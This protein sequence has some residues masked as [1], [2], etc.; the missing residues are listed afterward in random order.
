M[1]IKYLSKESVVKIH[2]EIIDR[3][4]KEK[5]IINEGDID[6]TLERVE[7]YKGENTEALLWKATI[8]LERIIIGHPFVDG[9][10]RTAFEAT[11]VF[12]QGNNFNIK[13]TEEEIIELL[14]SI[15][16]NQKNRFSI[17]NWLEHHILNL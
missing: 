12:L 16:Q 3:F 14:I 10:R 9:N 5:G 8:L 13:A 6:F 17:K 11:K 2:H 15:A 1:L 4:S 7:D